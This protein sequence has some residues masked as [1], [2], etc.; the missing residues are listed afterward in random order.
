MRD[1]LGEKWIDPLLFRIGASRLAK[2]TLE[3]I[4]G[5]IKGDKKEI[6]YF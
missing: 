1:I 5:K 6:K 3:S 2:R 4:L